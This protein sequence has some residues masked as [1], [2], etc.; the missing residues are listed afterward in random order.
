[1]TISVY[2][3][4]TARVLPLNDIVP[5]EFFI[6]VFCFLN[7]NLFGRFFNCFSLIEGWTSP[8]RIY[9]FYHNL[10]LDLI[11][12]LMVER[13]DVLKNRKTLIISC[14]LRSIIVVLLLFTNVAA[15]T[16]FPIIPSGIHDVGYIGMKRDHLFYTHH[17]DL[18]MMAVLGLTNGMNVTIAFESGRK[19]AQKVDAELIGEL[20][21]SGSLKNS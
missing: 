20:S 3:T 18:V 1:M 17:Q 16:Y 6:P 21:G 13:F 11:G 8:L 14:C 10:F 12:R 19:I 15:K 7:F 5:V 9:K 4:I 2:P